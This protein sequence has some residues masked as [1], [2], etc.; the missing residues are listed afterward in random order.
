MKLLQYMLYPREA[1]ADM[2][3]QGL[4]AIT[5]KRK[6][7]NFAGSQITRAFAETWDLHHQRLFFVVFVLSNWCVSRNSGCKK[8]HLR[9]EQLI[10]GGDLSHRATGSSWHRVWGSQSLHWIGNYLDSRRRWTRDSSWVLQSWVMSVLDSWIPSDVSRVRPLP[11]EGNRVQKLKRFK[12]LLGLPSILM[13][14]FQLIT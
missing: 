4:L 14:H 12:F 8:T 3:N 1:F 10:K 5:P 2:E 6:L 13:K 7:P 11:W 9:F